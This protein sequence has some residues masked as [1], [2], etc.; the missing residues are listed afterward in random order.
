MWALALSSLT[1]TALSVPT[2]GISGRL[3]SPIFF[4][5]PFPLPALRCLSRPLICLQPRLPLCGLV[6]SALRSLSCP[7]LFLHPCLPLC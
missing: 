4:F 3:G 1:G 7:S 5:E 2:R 6:G